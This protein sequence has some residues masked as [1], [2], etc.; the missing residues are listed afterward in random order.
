[1]EGFVK[2]KTSGF[3]FD[4][5]N[6]ITVRNCSVQWGNNRPAYFAHALESYRVTLL[7]VIALHADAAFPGKIKPRLIK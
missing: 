5:A 4:K 6:G 2:G 1:V 3:Y 7:N